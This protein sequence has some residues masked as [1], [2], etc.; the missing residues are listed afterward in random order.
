[1]HYHLERRCWVG[2]RLEVETLAGKYGSE[3]AARR[4]ARSMVATLR[5]RE[6]IAIEECSNA[7]GTERL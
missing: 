3:D 7:C 1:M 5:A 6:S 2:D 4:A